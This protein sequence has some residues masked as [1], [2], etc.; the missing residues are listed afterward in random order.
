MFLDLTLEFAKS[1]D[2]NDPLKSFRQD[3]LFP[4]FHEKEVRYF[5][6]NSLGLQPKN[7]R[8]YILEE[9]DDW[10]K[11]GVEGHFMSLRPWYS[12]HENLTDMMAKIVGAK[13]LEVV[14]THS[15]TTNLHLLLVS[16][17]SQ[18]GKEQKFY[19]RR[20]PFQAISMRFPP[21]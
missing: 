11:F 7:A 20:K 9:L 10:E 2:K 13:P 19:V 8:K 5:T 17:F 6:G 15:L 3:F 18:K 16:F 4:T 12:Y 1:L 14:V 21:K